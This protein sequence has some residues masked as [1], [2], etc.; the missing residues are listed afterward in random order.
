MAGRLI[1]ACGLS[2]APGINRRIACNL[3]LNRIV[4]TTSTTLSAD[5][6]RSQGSR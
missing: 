4:C 1:C 5:L 6:L 3:Q 2:V